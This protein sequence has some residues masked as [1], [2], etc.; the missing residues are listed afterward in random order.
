MLHFLCTLTVS[1][2]ILLISKLISECPIG[3]YT[4]QNSPCRSCP[5][6]SEALETGL[7]ECSCLEGYYR[8]AFE[9]REE[10]CTREYTGFNLT[11]R[12][13]IHGAWQDV[14]DNM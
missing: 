7:S 1:T 4:P 8:A 11:W 14:F 10:A 9:G 3:T 12:C 6:N 2:L 5:P 13:Y